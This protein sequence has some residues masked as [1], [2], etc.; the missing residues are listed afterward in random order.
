MQVIYACCAGLD[1]HKDSVFVCIRRMSDDGKVSEEIRVFGTKTGELLALGDWLVSKGV[2]HAA[3]ES[4]G[5][6]WKPIWNLLEDRLKLILVNAQHLKKVPGRKTDVKDCQWIAQ[7]LQFGLLKASFVPDRPQ[8]ELRDLTRQR[9]QLVADHSRVANRIQK[10]LEDAN[11]KLGSVASDVLGVSGRQML[12]ALIQGNCSAQH[13]AELARGRMRS[14]VPQLTEALNGRV[15]EHHRFMLK[16]LMEQ[17]ASLEK[18][19]EAFDQRIEQVM[20]PFEK[21]AIAQLD[22]MPGVNQRAAQNI[23][24]ETGTDMS[25]FG[26]AQGLAAWAG[27]CPGNN[28][29]AG[30]RKSGRITHGNRWLKSTLVQCSWGAARKKGSFWMGRYQRISRRR[31]AKRAAVAVAHSQL[32]VIYELLSTGQTYREMGSNYLNQK[33][34]DRLKETL[35]ARLE[36]MGYQVDLRPK[37]DAA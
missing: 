35:V 36:R 27:I 18:Q 25:R 30:K 21:A 1:V 16:M 6:Y 34:Q 17:V 15:N 23:I 28:Q 19:I 5:V 24:A 31:G 8:R 2:T 22:E 29:S 3:M 11:I 26:S 12:A 14:K 10:T 13:I 9:S 37:A 7:L 33:D 32:T 20:S 4:T